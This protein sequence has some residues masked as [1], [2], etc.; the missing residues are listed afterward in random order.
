MLLTRAMQCARS[1]VKRPQEVPLLGK[2]VGLQA[3]QTSALRRRAR[4]QA[5]MS[6]LAAARSGEPGALVASELGLVARERSG[7]GPALPGEGG[8]PG[9]RAARAGTERAPSARISDAR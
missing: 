7:S 8:L 9:A 1:G 3:A 2:S 6:A 4:A 5:R